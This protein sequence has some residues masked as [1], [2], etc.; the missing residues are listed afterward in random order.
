M[1]AKA[2]V[3][4][5]NNIDL[6]SYSENILV[7]RDSNKMSYEE[8]AMFLLNSSIYSPYWTKSLNLSTY[9]KNYKG[10]FN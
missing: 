6:L 5:D 7:S 1:L 9:K 3:N 2:Y 8:S 10:Y 4:Q